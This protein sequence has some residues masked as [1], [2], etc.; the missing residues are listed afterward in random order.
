MYIK[1]HMVTTEEKASC[2]IFLKPY[3]TSGRSIR[4]RGSHMNSRQP[5]R[6][7]ARVMDRVQKIF[8]FQYRH[9]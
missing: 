6:R 3:A 1:K 7:F 5:C 4:Y 9:R 8:D 2:E